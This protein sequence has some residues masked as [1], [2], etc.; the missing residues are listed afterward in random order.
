MGEN[1][2]E[3]KSSLRYFAILRKSCALEAFLSRA[4]AN[5]CNSSSSSGKGWLSH[6][7]KNL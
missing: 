5:V 3:T 1:L 2:I 7:K 6:E 4:L